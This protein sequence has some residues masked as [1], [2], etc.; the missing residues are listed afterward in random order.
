MSYFVYL[1]RC[2]DNS[3]YCG[4]TTD[5]KRRIKEHNS[6]SKSAKYTR[7]RRPV[8]LVYCETVESHEKALKREWEIKKLSKEKKENLVQAAGV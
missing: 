6:G 8:S 5:I 7:S 1:L 2:G 3:L 4:I